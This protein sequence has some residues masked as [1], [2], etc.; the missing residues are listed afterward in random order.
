MP[1]D[2]YNP[3]KLNFFILLFVVIKI[4]LNMLAM[5]HFGFQRD[6]L[7]HLALG[8]HLDWG[9][10]EVPPVIALLA[11]LSTTLFGGSVF[12]T[13]MFSTLAGGFIVWF[14]GKIVAEL[15]GGRFAI[16]LAC[17]ALIFAP[18]FAASDYL[19]QPVVFD[20]LWWVLAVYLIVR[21]INTSEPIHIYLLGVVIGVGLLTKYTMAF[22]AA[23]LL[24][25]L[26][27]TRQRKLLWS[28]PVLIAAAIAL[29]VFLPNLLWQFRHH[30]PVFT[31]MKNLREQQLNYIKPADFITNQLKVNG[32][33]LFVWLPGLIA[34][35]FSSALSKFRFI[36]FAYILVFAFL[37]YMNGKDYYL[38]GA[39]PMLFAAGG[40][41]F[42]KWI[43][44][45]YVVVRGIALVILTLL[46]IIF[47]PLALP[48]LP[49][50]QTIAVFKSLHIA[51][52]WEDQKEHP[53]S[54]DYA[55]MFGWDEMGNK[56]AWAYSGLK[57]EQQKHTQ[58]YADNYGDAGAVYHYGKKYHLPEVAS[59]NSSFTLWA[60]DSL[61]AHYIIYVD[62][63]GGGNVIKRLAPFVEKYVKLGEVKSRYA[64]EKGTT[65]FLL[66]NPKPGL[67][68][69]YQKEL[70]RK[71]LE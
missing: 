2:K 61:N 28:K 8:D 36:A 57:P 13:R 6:E 37:L 4:A 68:D 5:S 44:A 55:D 52:K 32:M 47:I 45:K 65:I 62:D 25:S 14:T 19:F 35:L 20:Q 41:S 54:Q 59:L 39:Y 27:F 31:H 3:Q 34:L 49:V 29:V 50:E 24:I 30:L 33:A 66:V 71:R 58:I 64:R 7:L 21:Y 43:K 56:V 16:A 38:F 60:P 40:Y 11:K 23:S 9:F 51:P 46:N 1:A 10:K 42:E 63:Q 17:L 67:N 69:I 26:L 12:A 15:G 22:F 53:L 18:A 48:I 70:A